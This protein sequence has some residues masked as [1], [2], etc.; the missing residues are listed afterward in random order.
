[1]SSSQREPHTGQRPVNSHDLQL[2]TP[3]PIGT[4]SYNTSRCRAR[5]QT[6]SFL[7]LMTDQATVCFCVLV[8]SSVCAY[9]EENLSRLDGSTRTDVF[10]IQDK[11]KSSLAPVSRKTQSHKPAPQMGTSS[12]VRETRLM[13]S[14][15]QIINHLCVCVLNCAK[16]NSRDI[17]QTNLRSAHANHLII[18]INRIN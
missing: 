17:R 10:L 3:R 14:A 5:P 6:P 4:R 11:F 7:L 15:L 1:M 2:H 16:K 8:L 9:R 12:M 13:E 18:R